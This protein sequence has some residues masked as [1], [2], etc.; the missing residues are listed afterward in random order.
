MN[1]K[2][3]NHRLLFIGTLLYFALSFINIQFAVLAMACMIT[4]FILLARDK[5]KTWCQGYC[6]RAN[7]YTKAGKLPFA[8]GH[9]TPKSFT[10]GNV[11]WYVLAY[12]SLNLL[13]MLGTT[14]RVAAGSMEPMNYPRFLL[15]FAFRSEL[16]Q[17]LPT[18]N[19][20]QWLTHFSY[21]FF[22]MMMTTSVVGLIMSLVYKPRTWCTICPVATMS[23]VALKGMRANSGVQKQSNTV[24]S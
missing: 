13:I 9:K 11:K 12:F 17:L 8:R 10:K 19:E 5:K 24:K 14:I 1:F 22:S 7:L 3:K 15:F 23:D 6:P 2:L 16:P 20:S 18:V 4:P 21:R